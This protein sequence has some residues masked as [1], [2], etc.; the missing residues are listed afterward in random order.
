MLVRAVMYPKERLRAE[1]YLIQVIHVLTPGLR[2]LATSPLAPLTIAPS[3]NPTSFRW[4]NGKFSGHVP[5][6]DR[7]CPSMLLSRSSKSW[8]SALFRSPRTHDAMA[9]VARNVAY[10]LR[11]IIPSVGYRREINDRQIQQVRSSAGTCSIVWG[12]ALL[13][14]AKKLQTSL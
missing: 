5:L 7:S 11:L 8:S 12:P 4:I 9:S 2:V 13:G 1:K 10:S 14:C 3:T 6:D